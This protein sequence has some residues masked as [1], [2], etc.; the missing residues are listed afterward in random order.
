MSKSV[1]DIFKWLCQPSITE[2]ASYAQ[3][4]VV[5]KS[6]YSEFKKGIYTGVTKR[7][8]SSL[9][10]LKQS[11][12]GGNTYDVIDPKLIDDRAQIIRVLFDHND[13]AYEIMVNFGTLWN[14]YN[15]MDVLVGVYGQP[16]R[17]NSALDRVWEYEDDIIRYKRTYHQGDIYQILEYENKKISNRFKNTNSEKLSEENRTKTKND[18]KNWN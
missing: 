1:D 4:E 12:L 18:I 7:E 17:S 10:N 11:Y 8:L 15:L 2:Y 6:K 13:I 16:N 5:N 14:Y 9:Y 3:N